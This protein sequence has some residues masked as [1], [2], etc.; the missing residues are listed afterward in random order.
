MTQAI[1]TKWEFTAAPTTVP[2]VASDPTT[3]LMAQSATITK[4]VADQEAQAATMTQ[5]H[6]TPAATITQAHM[7][8]AA[9]ITQA[10][11][12]PAAPTIVPEVASDPITILMAQSAI[13]TKAV[14]DQE[15]HITPVN[16][17]PAHMTPAHMT[18]AHMTPA[19]LTTVPEEV[20]DLTTQIMVESAT[21]IIAETDQTQAA[22]TAHQATAPTAI[23]TI[24]VTDT[25]TAATADQ[26]TAPTAIQTTDV[27]EIT[28]A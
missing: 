8:P 15:A 7:T 16:M 12:T 11:M 2:E 28:Q 18:P 22:T 26:A 27:T 3:I 25:T 5:A 21:I 24:D 13:I 4:A 9:T 23:Q 14:T 10:H 6:M 20:S 1:K 19:A 17:T